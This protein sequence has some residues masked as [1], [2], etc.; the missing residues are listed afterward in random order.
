MNIET[1]I[2]PSSNVHILVADDHEV[3]RMGIRNLLESRPHWKICAEAGTGQEAINKARQY[4][5]DVII[6]DITMPVMNGLDAASFIMRSQPQI[7]IVLFSLHL[8]QELINTFE[9]SG[10]RA[11]VCKGNAA[12]DLIDAVE[13]V[14]QGGKFFPGSTSGGRTTRTANALPS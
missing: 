3:M 8:S 1:K 12:R 2:P 7:P 5:P 4:N 10:I 6:M 13:T 14:L 11:A 9:G